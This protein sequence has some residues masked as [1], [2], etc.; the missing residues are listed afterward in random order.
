MLNSIILIG[1]SVRE[2]ETRFTGTGKKVASITI[3]VDRK[4]KGANGEKLTDFFR[5]QVWNKT[6]DFAEQYVKKGDV[7]AVKGSLT[8]DQNGEK[9]YVSVQ[10]D[11]LQLVSYGKN[12]GQAVEQEEPGWNDADDVPF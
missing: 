3:A 1:R 11:E 7:V 12:H 9:T 8:M 10:V 6:A 4:F 5:C 2:T